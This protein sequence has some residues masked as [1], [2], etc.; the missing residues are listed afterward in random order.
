MIYH[1]IHSLYIP[2]TKCHNHFDVNTIRSISI[3]KKRRREEEKKKFRNFPVR[4][5]HT[6]YL[7]PQRVMCELFNQFGQFGLKENMKRKIEKYFFK[8]Q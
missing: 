7:T 1:S 8:Q 2:I 3:E 6:I 5:L 4:P